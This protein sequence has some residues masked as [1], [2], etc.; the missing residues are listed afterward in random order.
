[1]FHELKSCESQ[2]KCRFA[3]FFTKIDIKFTKMDQNRLDS[4]QK[5]GITSATLR[6]VFTEFSKVMPN[7]AEKVPP[8]VVGATQSL[9]PA[10][11]F[12]SVYKRYSNHTCAHIFVKEGTHVRVIGRGGA[13]TRTKLRTKNSPFLLFSSFWGNFRSANLSAWG[14]LPSL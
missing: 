3:T 14:H 5:I 13:L 12:F 4:S 6:S 9:R 7:V 2:E 8:N 11:A 10:F 1:M